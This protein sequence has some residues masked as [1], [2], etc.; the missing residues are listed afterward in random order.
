M[1]EIL[2]F[3][4]GFQLE[5]LKQLI[6]SYNKQGELYGL[7][8]YHI[9]RN[10]P[11]FKIEWVVL[12]DS[13]WVKNKFDENN[14]HNVASLGYSLSIQ[15]DFEAKEKFIKSFNLLKKRDH[16]KGPHLSFPFQP[17]T[18]LGIVLGAKAVKEG[19]FCKDAV[20]WLTHVLNERIKI[21]HVSSFSKLFYKYIEHHL[22]DK[23]IEI[24]DMSQYS[25]LEELSLLEF[26]G[27]QNIFKIPNQQES[28]GQIRKSI[29]RL[30]VETQPERIEPEK[31]PIIWAAANESIK[32]DINNLLLSPS[33]VSA[34]LSRFE[35]A[36]R[37]W[38][39]DPENTKNLVRWPINQ[40][41]EV[42]D[43]IWMI[44]RSYFDD[45]VDEETLPKFGHSSYKPDFAIPSLNLLI[46]VKYAYKKEDFKKIEK[47]IMQD[48]IGYLMNTQQYKKIIVFIYDNSSSVQE[49]DIARRDLIKIDEI[50]DVIIVSKPSQLP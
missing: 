27:M 4:I 26:G 10:I 7:F 50:E 30:L 3:Q 24:S 38:R 11:E 33:F 13:E 29:L 1:T 18:F 22:K 36:M 9:L 48:T 17:L 37:R 42:Q 16:F 49:H 14:V 12:C 40:E 35:H 44:L 5:Y 20:D 25:S 8:S 45:V 31:A 41:K 2:G 23:V 28:L 39:Y 19:S 15:D 32:K 21:G 46:E 34:I 47:E 43:I 6:H